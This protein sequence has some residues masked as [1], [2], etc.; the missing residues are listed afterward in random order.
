MTIAGLAASGRRIAVAHC[1]GLAAEAARDAVG[2]LPARLARRRW[3]R[4]HRLLDQRL[5]CYIARTLLGLE[6][7]EIAAALGINRNTVQR[8]VAWVE[9]RREDAAV[10]RWLD[11]I[12]LSLLP[13]PRE[14]VS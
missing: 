12:E 9:E 8:H 6:A 14:I 13:S 4:P 1:A 2:R 11:E 10:D 7:I 3:A 5:A